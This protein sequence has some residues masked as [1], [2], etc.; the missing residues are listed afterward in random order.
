MKKIPGL[1]P[2]MICYHQS[3]F[4][5]FRGTAAVCFAAHPWHF[6]AGVFPNVM[7]IGKSEGGFGSELERLGFA[8]AEGLTPYP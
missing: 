8:R 7:R 2:A 6:Y 1:V 3:S 4:S 5:S